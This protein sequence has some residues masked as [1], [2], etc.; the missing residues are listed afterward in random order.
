MFT[1]AFLFAILYYKHLRKL[2][3]NDRSFLFVRRF[4]S[5]EMRYV[6]KLKFISKINRLLTFALYSF[7]C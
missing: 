6:P 7:H 3:T 2:Q 4:L 1:I 5:A